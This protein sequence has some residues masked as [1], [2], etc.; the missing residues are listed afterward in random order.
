MPLREECG[1]FGVYGDPQ[2]AQIVYYGLHSLQHRGQE[3][4]GI[5]SAEGQRMHLTKGKGLITEVFP[6]GGL[7][8]LPGD[9]AIGHVRYS[10]G[11]GSGYENVQPL[12]FLSG[13][14]DM[15][16]AHNGAL[17]NA[18][19]MKRLLETQGSIFQTASDSELLAHMIRRSLQTHFRDKVRDALRSLVG[20]FAFI[21][22][23]PNEMIAALDKNALRPLC[24]GKIG[25]ATVI[26]SESCAFDIIGAT[27]LRDVNPGEM[28]VVDR[29]GLHSVQFDI[30]GKKHLCSMEYIYFSR[31]DSV[32]DG[33]NVHAARKQL[34]KIIAEES[35]VE[36][37]M[38]VGVPDSSTSAAI[39]YAEQ[40]GIPYE[41]GLIKNRYVGRTFI[42]PS[43]E[44]R[45]RGV[46]MKLSA[47]SGLVRGKRLIV[48]DDSIVR[49][50][51]MR[52]IVQMLR[53]AGA[54]EVH[55]R[56]SSPSIKHPCFYGIDM[57]SY[58]EL[59]SAN[60]TTEE[61][62]ALLQADSLHFLSIDGMLRAFGKSESH[63]KCGRCLACFTGEYPTPVDLHDE[64][65]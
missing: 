49:G 29:E 9:S 24:I 40:S 31:P 7:D 42:Q 12:L 6:G 22:L 3:G 53:E 20:G 39:G 10:N 51:T 37:D 16:L 61:L 41:M 4:A 30:P 62:C 26:S 52:R 32:L 54:K 36:A 17:A 28:I 43:Q 23:T 1:I 2:A 56:I 19:Q 60:M 65:L 50:T 46:R 47:V 11:D 57:H 18:P 63:A 25:N 8:N 35:P 45:E 55:L 21:L 59:V 38:V 13:Q 27:F 14:G 44:M 64:V 58:D 15:A 33:I 5:V 34:G 48:L